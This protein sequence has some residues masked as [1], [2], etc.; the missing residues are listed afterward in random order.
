MDVIDGKGDVMGVKCIVG[1]GIEF[2][3]GD[4]IGKEISGMDSEDMEMSDISDK[5]DG[6]AYDETIFKGNSV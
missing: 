5:G 2:R 6:V 1:E 4:P 3:R